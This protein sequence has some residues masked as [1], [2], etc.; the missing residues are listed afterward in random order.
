MKNDLHICG[1]FFDNEDCE[2]F[3]Y[4]QIMEVINKL[5]AD[6]RLAKIFCVSGGVVPWMVSNTNSNR[7]HSDL[8]LIV[9]K[10]H[11][12]II[13]DWLKEYNLHNTN[14]DSLSTAKADGIDYGVNAVFDG[15]PIGFYPYEVVDNDIVQRSFFPKSTQN[16]HYLKTR[17]I[18][19]IMEE[20]YVQSYINEDGL[21]INTTSLEVIKVQ[22]ENE[23][24]SNKDVYD[25]VQIDSIGYDESR[26][27]V[28]KE[29]L[30]NMKT[31]QIKSDD[32]IV[33]SEYQ[34]SIRAHKEALIKN[35][36]NKVASKFGNSGIEKR[37]IDKALKYYLRLDGVL[38]DDIG[39]ESFKD[40]LVEIEDELFKLAVNT[41]KNFI[42]ELESYSKLPIVE[43]DTLEPLKSLIMD[44]KSPSNTDAE[45]ISLK[46]SINRE[47][48]I[49]NVEF[50]KE[51]ITESIDRIAKEYSDRGILNRHIAKAK[52]H[53]LGLPDIYND[54]LS[55]KDFELLLRNIE[56]ELYILAENTK[57]N[58]IKQLKEDIIKNPKIKRE[59]KDK[60]TANVYFKRAEKENIVI[61]LIDS[62]ASEYSDSGVFNRHI[63]KAYGIFLN[64]PE[65][66]N[67]DLSFEEFNT[68]LL[69]IEEELYELAEQT[70]RNY[71][72]FRKEMEGYVK[73]IKKGSD[74]N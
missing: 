41:E 50:R 34:S 26:Y 12:P 53:Y 11:M 21:I 40:I 7:M 73:V 32:I 9:K 61:R 5:F 3:T 17:T 39:L 13:R 22:K 25:L 43:E 67:D 58:Y 4:E 18:P 28:V 72:S 15:I 64:R 35:L 51:K 45:N 71:E 36:I 47:N 20:E 33:Q 60:I 54:N 66:S 37:H 29:A 59:D 56:N 24:H 68:F 14:S 63:K 27:N 52:D 69:K 16:P 44:T 49:S 70:K 8:D 10:E 19:N 46:E 30:S 55:I 31:E 48:N 62:I 42:K 65:I 23:R 38:D 6:E 74:Y 1:N 2:M 57:N